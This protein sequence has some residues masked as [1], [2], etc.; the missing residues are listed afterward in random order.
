MTRDWYILGKRAYGPFG[1]ADLLH[2][3]EMEKLKG[4]HMVS[5]DKQNW[6]RLDSLGFAP[7]A[8]LESSTDFE[9]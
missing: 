6:Q 4:N 7:P 8:T 3:I 1:F 2:F 9:G 5:N